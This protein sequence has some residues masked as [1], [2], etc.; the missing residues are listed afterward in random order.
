MKRTGIKIFYLLFS[1]LLI[2]SCKKDDD[3]N[4]VEDLK[5]ENRKS[6]GTSAED[7][8]SDDIYKKLTVE[9]VYSSGFKPTETA[10]ISFRSFLTERLNKPDGISFVET[11]ID[12]PTGAP[13]TI[14][15]I[16]AIEELNRTIYT[17]GTTI[18]VYIFFANGNS[19]NDTDTTV[20]LGSSYLNT[21][22]V[23]YEKTLKELAT[24][25]INLSDL[26][27]TTMQHEFGHI[28]GLVN[29]Q[30]DDIHTDHEDIAHNKH[31]KIEDCLMYFESNI[32][33]QIITRFSGR[34][35]ISVLDPLCIEDL[36]AKGGK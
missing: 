27:S 3:P 35:S 2:T 19:S 29:I 26:E 8:L 22:I 34:K 4:L 17:E 12:Q 21:S 20:T 23:I 7:L 25:T 30:N 11:S 18:A 24:G 16:K 14:D 5:A 1:F 6:L 28:L 36:Q 31:C 32:R 33:F 13:Y 10:M 15:E 9:F